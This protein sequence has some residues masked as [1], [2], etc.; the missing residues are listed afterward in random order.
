RPLPAAPEWAQPGPWVVLT[1][2]GTADFAMGF[3]PPQ[4][5]EA[6]KAPAAS[7]WHVQVARDH[8][9]NQLLSDERV[10]AAEARLS[11]RGLEP[12]VYFARV[13]GVDDDHFEG[14]PSRVGQ[15]EVARV[16]LQQVAG[17]ETRVRV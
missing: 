14:P 15:I 9:F 1:T 7:L 5:A 2:G 13:S 4:G 12:G 6:Q 10:S 8:R 11:A 3:G 17:G 16:R